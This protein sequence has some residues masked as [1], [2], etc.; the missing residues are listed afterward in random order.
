MNPTAILIA[1]AAL[2]GLVLFMKEKA[3]TVLPEGAVDFGDD[4]WV[5]SPAAPP[6]GFRRLLGS[7][8]TPSLTTWAKKI[9]SEHGQE[10]IGTQV[11]FE[12]SGKNYLGIVE[13]H[14]HEPGG[15]LKP[16]GPHHGISLF[17][18]A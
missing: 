5:I 11:P 15:P 18:E 6:S 12:D 14:Y 7:E 13:M 10:P 2:G 17:V 1:I 8:V 4:Y 3:P 16:W 9:L